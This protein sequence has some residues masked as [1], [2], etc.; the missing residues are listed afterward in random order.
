MGVK[1]PDVVA[2]A[3][4]PDDFLIKGNEKYYKKDFR[5][6]LAL[7]VRSFLTRKFN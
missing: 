2:T 5:G 3:L 6:A 4:K 7:D 1:P